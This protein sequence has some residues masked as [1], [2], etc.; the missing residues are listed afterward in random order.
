MKAEVSN[1]VLH[2]ARHLSGVYQQQGRMLVDSDWNELTDILR[3]LGTAIGS[4]AIGT[5]VPRHGGLLAQST[6]PDAL[7]TLRN[8]GGLVAAAGVI[9]KSCRAARAPTL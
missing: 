5:G 8:Q 3:H 1:V 7:L 4:E 9:A 6:P 2:R